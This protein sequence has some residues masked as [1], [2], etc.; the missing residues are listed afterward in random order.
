M[1]HNANAV[2]LNCFK[3]QFDILLVGLETCLITKQF[4]NIYVFIKHHLSHLNLISRESCPTKPFS[5]LRGKEVVQSP[6]ARPCFSEMYDVTVEEL[7]PSSHSH[8]SNQPQLQWKL[9]PVRHWL[10]FTLTTQ[11]KMY[12]RVL[13]FVKSSLKCFGPGNV[14]VCCSAF[15]CGCEDIFIQWWNVTQCPARNYCVKPALD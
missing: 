5:E 11:T 15:I 3:Q 9:H 1:F 12:F 7:I 14:L 2:V 13:D 8:L 6:R 4:C 10:L